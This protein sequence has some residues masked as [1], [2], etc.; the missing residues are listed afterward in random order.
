MKGIVFRS[1]GSWYTVRL[2]SGGMIEARMKGKF[3]LQE[4]K[5]TNPVSVGDHVELQEENGS[6][7]INGIDNR[8]NYIIR[9]SN[10]LSR[11]T[12]ILASNIDQALLIITLISPV[13]SLG[14]IDRF[15]VSA[16]SFHIRTILVFNKFDLLDEAFIQRQHEIIDIYRKAGYHCI[17]MS[18]KTGYH[19]D[20]LKTLLIGKTTMLAGHSGTGKSTILNMLNPEVMKQRTATISEFSNKGK[21]TTTFAEMFEIMPGAF[22][23]DTPGIKD[24]GL[25]H[26]DP[27]EFKDYFREFLPFAPYCKFNDCKH[28][29]EPQC[30][31]RKAA[32]EGQ[33]S[34]ERYGSYLSMFHNPN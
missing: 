2:E 27:G 11:Q 23:I 21:H 24:F 18:A 1:T 33:I 25:V 9:R 12:H 19:L 5:H 20:E 4:I 15:V 13:T 29:T 16:E 14:F 7:V 22:I 31:V 3:R 26:L 6:Y 28:I 8:E 34:K 10:N 17:E 30:A 32:E